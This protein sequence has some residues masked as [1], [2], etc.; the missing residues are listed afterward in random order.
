MAV[1]SAS[2]SNKRRQPKPFS[3][4]R[5]G[6]GLLRH[7]VL[8]LLC[9]FAVAPLL[10][11]IGTALKPQT[12]VYTNPNLLPNQPTLANFIYVLN[13]TAFGR[14]FL[15]TLLL[16]GG[17]TLLSITIATLAGYAL[18]RYR[19]WGWGVYGNTLLLVQMFP[20]VMLGI[21]L[22]LIFTKLL[23][24]DSLWA[25]LITYMTFAL[26]F[27]VWMLK[28]YFDGIPR[29]IEEAAL[30]D[31]ASRMG[32]L[33][34]IV[35]PLSGPGISTVAVFAFLLAWNEFFFA[36]IFLVSEDNYTLQMGLYTF[37]KQFF[38]RWEYLMTA[39]VLTTLPV[40]VFFFAM[41]RYL[42]RGLIAG[43][44]KG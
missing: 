25:L 6:L 18:S 3:P 4:L 13:E 41:Q 14:W 38:T 11:A 35:L 9:L 22:F 26:A 40:L 34:R 16:A 12:E 32:V 7:V 2:Q 8:W 33:W 27:S 21:P 31:G 5:F 43:A 20:G 1:G 17:T 24:V 42:T 36:Y 15:N 30:I 10:W 23:L 37:I 44:T 29:E 28:G 19:F 39:S